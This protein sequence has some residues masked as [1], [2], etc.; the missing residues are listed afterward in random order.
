MSFTP[1]IDTSEISDADLDN[2]SGGAFSPPGFPREDGDGRFRY[3]KDGWARPF[4]DQ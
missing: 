1:Q 4:Q 2:I 3:E